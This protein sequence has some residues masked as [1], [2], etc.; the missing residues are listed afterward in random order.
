MFVER[1]H[2]GSGCAETSTQKKELGYRVLKF[3]N[4]PVK[5][6]LHELIRTSYMKIPHAQWSGTTAS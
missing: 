6:D 3:G 4:A 1:N 2:V 5:T